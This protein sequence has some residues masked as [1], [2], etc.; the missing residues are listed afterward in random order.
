MQ[1]TT[2]NK[3]IGYSIL[4]TIFAFGGLFVV[5]NV[6]PYMGIKPWR[7]VPAENKWRFP[8]GYLPE[9]FGLKT[10]QV[11]IQTPDSLL[12]KALLVP[13]NLDT[14]YAVV[15]QLHGISNCKETN[16]PRAKILADSGYASLLLDLRAHGESE[17]DY[18]TFGYKEKYDL[19]AVADTL[20]KLMPGCPLAIW[21]ASLG[22]AIALEAMAVEPRF[23]FGIVESTFDEYTKVYAEYGAD[24]M[25]GLRPQWLFNRVMR[26]SG[27]IAHFDPF[28]VKPVVSAEKIE[29]PVLFMHGDRD[30][31]IPMEFNKRNYEALKNEGK[32]WVTVHGA[33]HNNLWA[34]DGA[35]LKSAVHSF[36]AATRRIH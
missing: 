9:N 8:Q 10:Q 18:C 17:G 13:S 25:L 5:D 24:Y 23:A 1:K 26:R 14:T 28:A 35:Q 16:F 34:V 11:S 30:P 4:L 29:H 3:A 19:K 32:R 33:G 21:G 7:M 15:V 27:E 22:G 2:R 20:S 6:F 31:R 12:L 36:L